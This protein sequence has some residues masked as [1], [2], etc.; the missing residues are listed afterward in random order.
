LPFKPLINSHDVKIV[1]RFNRRGLVVSLFSARILLTTKLKYIHSRLR[2][3]NMELS[4]ACI[5]QADGKRLSAI[6]L[7]K[8]GFQRQPRIKRA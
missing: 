1:F 2:A 6:L 5:D 4:Y 7:L 8:I 3:K